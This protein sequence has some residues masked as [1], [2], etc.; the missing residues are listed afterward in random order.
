MCLCLQ[1]DGGAQQLALQMAEKSALEA[2]PSL[3]SAD[4][5]TSVW[6][7]ACT[8]QCIRGVAQCV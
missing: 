4:E 3:P 1:T 5:V 8:N 7:L 2:D 6:H